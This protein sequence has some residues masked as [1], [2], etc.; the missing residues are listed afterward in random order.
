MPIRARSP[1]QLL[2]SLRASLHAATY[3]T[4]ALLVSLAFVLALATLLNYSKF[5]TTYTE[6]SDRRVALVTAW[7]RDSIEVLL[8]LGLELKGL[9]AAPGVLEQAK[10]RYPYIESISLFET[11]SGRILYSTLSDQVGKATPPTWLS[12]QANATQATWHI[13]GEDPAVAGI[14]LDSSFLKGLG[15]IA[16]VYSTADAHAKMELMR[17]RLTLTALTVFGAFALL[18][19]ILALLATRGMRRTLRG[20]ADALDPSSDRAVDERLPEPLRA[21]IM[22]FREAT[23][24]AEAALAE[25]ERDLAASE[26]GKAK[27]GEAAAPAGMAAGGVP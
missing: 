13:D 1:G 5:L 20:L 15:G 6:L 4:L 24:Q 16:I 9:Q 3:V 7:T 25:A 18:A 14:R 27:D 19:I 23:T 12:A 26:H 17:E 21:P 8:N 10:A 2:R 11:A 22:A